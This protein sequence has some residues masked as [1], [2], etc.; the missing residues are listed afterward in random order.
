MFIV[1]RTPSRVR[2]RGTRCGRATFVWA[3]GIA[4]A[5]SGARGEADALE[6]YGPSSATRGVVFV[7]H[8]VVAGEASE[9]FAADRRIYLGGF[10]PGTSAGWSAVP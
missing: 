5:A 1:M 2:P 9:M 7:L 8:P 4:L 10:E 3:L 6:I